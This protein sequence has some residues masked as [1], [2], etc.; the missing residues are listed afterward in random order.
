MFLTM[1]DLQQTLIALRFVLSKSFNLLGIYKNE[2]TKVATTR[3]DSIFLKAC[4]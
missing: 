2:L 3:S 4:G 1:K